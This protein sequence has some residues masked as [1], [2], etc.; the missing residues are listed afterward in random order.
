M[1]VLRTCL[2]GCGRSDG[3]WES[4]TL[5]H[6]HPCQPTEPLDAPAQ[7]GGAREKGW[8]R[9]KSR[10]PRGRTLSPSNVP[11]GPPFPFPPHAPLV[12]HTNWQQ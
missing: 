4:T 8:R 9:T 1:V 10:T 11:S 6:A 5:S 3:P 7:R 12:T 2:C